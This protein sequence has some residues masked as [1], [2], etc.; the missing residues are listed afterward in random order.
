MYTPAFGDQTHRVSDLMHEMG[1]VLYTANE[2]YPTY[3]CTSIMGHCPSY[4]TVS[5]HDIQDYKDAFGVEDA[6]N[7]TYVQ[8]LSGTQLRHFFEGGYL[9]G[10]GRTIHQERQYWVDR[11]TT[12]ITGTYTTYKSVPRIINNT[13]DTTPNYVTYAEIPSQNGE[14]CL[15][16]RGQA[17]GVESQVVV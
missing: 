10:I 14:W 8:V 4:T 2:H 7:A 9:G 17:G 11:S 1:H 6:P 13:D 16:I 5:G 15:K 12:G 3:N